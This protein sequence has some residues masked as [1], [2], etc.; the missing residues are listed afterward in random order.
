MWFGGCAAIGMAA[1]IL[2]FPWSSAASAKPLESSLTFIFFLVVLA[3]AIDLATWGNFA[4][5]ALLPFRAKIYAA[6]DLISSVVVQ[7]PLK[8][9]ART[10][11]AL[12][13]TN[14]IALGSKVSLC[15]LE[16]GFTVTARGATDKLARSY[17]AIAL[18]HTRHHPTLKI[19]INFDEKRVSVIKNR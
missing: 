15:L 4:I 2:I 13:G 6:E 17:N 10:L 8:S 14:G 9:R 19:Q 7:R 11:S 3:A 12:S 16:Q 5:A 18:R 1:V